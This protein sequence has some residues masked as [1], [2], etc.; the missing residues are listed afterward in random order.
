MLRDWEANAKNFFTVLKSLSGWKTAPFLPCIN[1]LLTEHVHKPKEGDC[2]VVVWNIWDNMWT[3][4]RIL[5]K[6]SSKAHG[7]KTQGRMECQ[8][9]FSPKNNDAERMTVCN[10]KWCEP[11]SSNNWCLQITINHS[12]SRTGLKENACLDRPPLGIVPRADA[13]NQVNTGALTFLTT[14][15]KWSTDYVKFKRSQT[16]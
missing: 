14:V 12:Q 8:L 9:K 1:G 2:G 11:G 5:R 3:F 10:Q 15:A 13:I 7:G 4:F 16:A 6:K